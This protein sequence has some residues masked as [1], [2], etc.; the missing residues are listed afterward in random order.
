MSKVTPG[1]LVNQTP[2]QAVCPKDLAHEGKH[3]E[4]VRVAPKHLETM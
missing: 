1:L 3:L 4:I 2:L